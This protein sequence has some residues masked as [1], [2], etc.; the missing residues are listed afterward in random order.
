MGILRSETMKQGTLVLPAERARHFVELIGRS[1]Q[2]QIQDMNQHSMQRNYRKYI[3][4]YVFVCRLFD[5]CLELKIL[6]VVFDLFL[7]RLL[8]VV[9]RRYLLSMYDLFLFC[10]CINFVDSF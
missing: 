3:Q 8:F 6:S 5:Y 7:T 1:V 2:I 9:Y 4:R 10:I